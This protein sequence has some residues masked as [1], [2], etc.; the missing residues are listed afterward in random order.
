M[1]YCIVGPSG[2]GKSTIVNEL[3]KLGYT[4]ANSYTTRPK[5]TPNETG[6]TFIT[7]EKFDKLQN[8]VAYTIFNSYRYCVTKEMLDGCDLYI[9]DPPGIKTLKDSGYTNF[10]TIGLILDKNKCTNR[11]LSRG[12]TLD[13]VQSRLDN[14]DKIFDGFENICDYKIDASK[15]I[16][17]IVNEILQ[18]IK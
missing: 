17:N 11:M 18:I 6:H 13:K 16:S 10:K 3:N 2:S 14:D 12:D 4:S 7:D 1:L 5:R 9:V 15:S 8:I